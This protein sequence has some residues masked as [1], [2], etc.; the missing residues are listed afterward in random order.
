MIE[1]VYGRSLVVF[2]VARG[3]LIW[4]R[5]VYD[6]EEKRAMPRAFPIVLPFTW[7]SKYNVRTNTV[8]LINK[9]FLTQD[10]RGCLNISL[11]AYLKSSKI[12]YAS[13]LFYAMLCYAMLCYAMLCYAML[14]CSILFHT[15]KTQQEKCS[16]KKK[17]S[18]FSFMIFK[19]S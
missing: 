4:Q 12:S 5:D 1:Y 7:S 13:I 11:Q 10:S 17:I 3:S 14:F 6:E 16:M 18:Y 9:L 19:W 8:I 15:W 2:K